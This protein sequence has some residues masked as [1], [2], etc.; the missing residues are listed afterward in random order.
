MLRKLAFV[1][2]GKSNY[3][4]LLNKI[5]QKNVE[6]AWTQAKSLAQLKISLPVDNC[7]PWLSSVSSLTYMLPSHSQ[8]CLPWISHSVTVSWLA[9]EVV[10]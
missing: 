9:E 3:P 4:V 6:I 2:E 1:S 7:G 5:S 10:L 8:I